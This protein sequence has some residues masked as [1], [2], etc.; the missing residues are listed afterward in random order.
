M[1]S[2]AWAIEDGYI[3]NPLRGIV[4]V[5]S[6]MLFGMPENLLE[7]FEE[8]ECKDIGNRAIRVQV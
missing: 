2:T 5:A 4:P 8:R 6:K 7:G 1:R 3:L